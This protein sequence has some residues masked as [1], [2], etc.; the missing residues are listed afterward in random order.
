MNEKIIPIEECKR[1][2]CKYLLSTER[3]GMDKLIVWLENNGFFESPAST[4][5][6]GARSGG[7]A[8]HSFAVYSEY[9]QLLKIHNRPELQDKEFMNSLKIACLLHDCC[10]AGVYLDNG[11]SY[12][13][14]TNHP[15][16][17]S[18]LSIEIIEK[19]IKLNQIEKMMIQ[20]HMG[21]YGTFEFDNRKGKGE[22]GIRDLCT[23]QNN[24]YVKLM[25][26]ADD[27]SSQLLES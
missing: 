27:L 21:Y 18:I 14:N 25:Y 13:Y 8:F 26:F 19:F 16:G 4:K 6:H 3:E 5:F 7:L 9:K 15:I 1:I 10:K 11:D 22:Y 17:H 23:A 12:S 2:I 20:F 24:I